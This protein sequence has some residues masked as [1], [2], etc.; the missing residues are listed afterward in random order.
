[1]YDFPLNRKAIFNRGMVA[2]MVLM[3]RPPQPCSTRLGWRGV[4]R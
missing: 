3:Q 4:P 1:V 2:N